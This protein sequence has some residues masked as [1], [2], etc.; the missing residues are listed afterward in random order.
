MNR[1]FLG[2]SISLC[3]LVLFRSH[4]G[5]AAEPNN[6]LN[7]DRTRLVL[8]NYMRVYADNACG[9]DKPGAFAAAREEIGQ[10]TDDSLCD[11][12]KS[13]GPETPHAI[14][15]AIYDSR[16]THPAKLQ[17]VRTATKLYLLS[18]SKTQSKSNTLLGAL[19]SLGTRNDIPQIASL[20]ELR[21][22]FTVHEGL[23]AIQE[24][25]WKE[26]VVYFDSLLEYAE[27][28]KIDI[29]KQQVQKLRDKLIR[30]GSN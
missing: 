6:Q 11:I 21:S 2:I 1:L 9:V 27:H 30:Q 8:R 7:A 3:S 12:E 24:L 22:E 20:A 13:I 18:G 4:V 17:L 14:V 29:N 26:D 16:L 5:Y 23:V 28:R 10:I 15:Y 19:R 25:G